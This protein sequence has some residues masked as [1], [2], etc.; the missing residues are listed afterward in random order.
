M[1]RTNGD[2]AGADGR[3]RDLVV[4][5]ERLEGELVETVAALISLG[6]ERIAGLVLA[7]EVAGR[8]ALLPAGRVRS[9]LPV[10]AMHPV[11]DAPP[12]VIGTFALRGLA[13][14]VIDLARRLGVVREPSLEAQIVVLGGAR[15]VGVL[16]DR[17]LAVEEGVEVVQ[18][19]PPEGEEAWAGTRL[20]P[21]LCRWR[22]EVLPLLEP[23]A[24]VRC[25]EGEAA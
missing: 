22:D 3:R 17:V 19:R 15:L 1:A 25:A 11:P 8:R 10:L 6:P 21:A 9:V 12:E 16:V 14:T 24:I 4:R 7:V 13:V 2:A 23:A 5:L 20:V 18:G